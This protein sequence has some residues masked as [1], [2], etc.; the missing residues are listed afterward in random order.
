MHQIR[1]WLGLSPDPVTEAPS[2]PTADPIPALGP[3]GLETTCLPKY[4]SLN[5]PMVRCPYVAQRVAENAKQPFSSK[6]DRTSLEES[7]LRSLFV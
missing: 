5:P 1:F 4:V 7:L 3:P 6:I 2:A